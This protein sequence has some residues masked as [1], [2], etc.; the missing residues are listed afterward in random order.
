M[1][2]CFHRTNWLLDINFQTVV[3]E[4]IWLFVTWYFCIFVLWRILGNRWS[5]L[6][7]QTAFLWNQNAATA[8]D[9]Q[10][11]THCIQS[12]S[13]LNLCRSKSKPKAFHI[14]FS[15]FL[16]TRWH[17]FV[18]CAKDKDINL[19]HCTTENDARC[20]MTLKYIPNLPTSSFW[21]K[22]VKLTLKRRL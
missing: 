6:G 13:N 18:H 3:S 7:I 21:Y 4:D 17:T 20:W 22:V 14:S 15:G 5:T 8:F 16:K 12:L 11:L 9:A 1:K 19:L 2:L 10:S